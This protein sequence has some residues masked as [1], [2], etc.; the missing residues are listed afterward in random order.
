MA[1][2]RHKLESCY[3]I[4]QLDNVVSLV[5][6]LSS[7]YS[8]PHGVGMNTQ[9]HGVPNGQSLVHSL[10]KAPA[11][12]PI[13]ISKVLRCSPVPSFASS[14]PH[15]FPT[16]PPL[17]GI[18]KQYQNLAKICSICFGEAKG[19]VLIYHICNFHLQ[20]MGKLLLNPLIL[21]YPDA[22]RTIRYLKILSFTDE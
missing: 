4:C 11:F 13:Q 15:S 20:W 14:L 1:K 16:S 12:A 22:E 5:P 7:L 19:E 10:S 9:P 2:L 21:P 3:L 17:Y 6:L 18:G 8:H